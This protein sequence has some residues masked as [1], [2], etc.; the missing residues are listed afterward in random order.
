MYSR[1]FSC[2]LWANGSLS[3]LKDC[4]NYGQLRHDMPAILELSTVEPYVLALCQILRQGP[5]F[6]K[7]NF[8]SPVFQ[9]GP[10]LLS[11]RIRSIDDI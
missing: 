4:Y 11:L 6:T 8:L 5:N 2:A 9:F 3:F 7:Q 10:Y 1:F